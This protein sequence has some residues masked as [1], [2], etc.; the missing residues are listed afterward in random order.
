[1]RIFFEIAWR[2]LVSAR[3]RTLMIGAALALVTMFLVLLMS[4]SQ[5][6]YDTIVRS[7]TTLL[8]GHVNVGGFYKAKATDSNP[9]IT[10]RDEVR[11]IVEREVAGLKYMVD[12]QRGF[13][14]IT[15][16]TDSLQSVLA[17]ID[18]HQEQ[19]LATQLRLAPRRSYLK[20]GDDRVTG[21]PERLA[22]GDAIM[23]FSGQA[24]RL[25]VDVG[26]RITLSA[27]LID[28]TV[29]TVDAEVVAIAE[30]VGFLSSWNT[31]VN[32]ATVRKLYQ[33]NEQTTGA[34]MI[35]LDD[36]GRAD[37]VMKTLRPKLADAGFEL[38]DHAPQPFWA[39]FD[40]VAGEDWTGLRLDLTTW[41]DEIAPLRWTLSAVETVSGALVLVLTV[42]IVVGIMN[43]MWIS[44]RERT[45][46]VGTL[47]AIGMGRREVLLMFLLE[48]LMLGVVFA[49]LGA[50]VGAGIALLIDSASIQ[51][52][53][54]AMRA[55][56]LSDVLH[57]VLEP[58]QVLMAVLGFTAITALAAL[59]PAARA[60]RMQPVTAIHHVG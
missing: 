19:R 60:A 37:D 34:V 25:A 30:D 12:R 7:S 2:N 18:I 31:F 11:T 5:G 49:S 16:D 13:A 26:E 23:L 15:S 43:T 47:R 40:V 6:L 8:S 42:I 27:Q 17:G 44:V 24:A 28:G 20:D 4:L 46:E 32:Q 35:Y 54:E 55:V 36:P 59:W 38:L 39:K 1:M 52:P 53:I 14:T 57:L 21:D 51:V 58:L 10:R 45:N 33:L 9:M 41:R 48:A 22:D 29:N 3:R 50:G 56:L